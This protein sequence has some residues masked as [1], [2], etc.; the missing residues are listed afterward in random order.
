MC[1]HF[2]GLRL[3]HPEQVEQQIEIALDLQVEERVQWA[4]S[5][6]TTLGVLREETLIFLTLLDAESVAATEF[7]SVVDER[8]RVRIQQQYPHD[9]WNELRQ[10]VWTKILDSSSR[11]Q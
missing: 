3:S 9:L 7:A 8:V 5:R 11:W 6:N 1:N 10:E 2:V 4:R